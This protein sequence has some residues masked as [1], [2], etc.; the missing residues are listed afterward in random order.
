[1]MTVLSTILGA[2]PL[3]LATGAGAESRN[4]IGTVIIAGLALSSFL[5]LVVTPVL[6][7]LLVRFTRPRGA[8]EKM[9]ERELGEEA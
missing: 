9:L 8:V 3:L 5:M 2:L 7:D 6:Y 4:A 1:M